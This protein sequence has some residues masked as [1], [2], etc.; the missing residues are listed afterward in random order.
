MAAPVLPHIRI[1]A[2]L[3]PRDGRF[4]SGPSKVPAGA[5]ARLG[6]PESASLLGTSH[7]QDPVR[8]LVASVRAGMRALWSLPDDVA[9]VLGNGGASQFWDVAAASLIGEHSQ[10]TVFGEFGGKFA[11]AVAGA[12][13]L[14]DPDVIE[15]HPGTRSEPAARAGID[16]YALVHN[17]TSTGVVG[18]A[19]RPA[20]TDGDA[21]VAVDATS[22]AGA[23]PTDHR[24]WDLYYF[25]PQKVF[26]S[27]GGLWC[28]LLNP[29]ARARVAD[30]RAGESPRWRPASLDLGAAIEQSE[31]D[32]TTNTPAIATLVLL[33]E[34]LRWLNDN[35]GIDFAAG[36]SGASAAILYDWAERT[37]WTAPFVTDPALR[38]PVVGTIDFDPTV[39][40]PL[41]A[42]TLRANG[43]VDTE[44]Y[45]KLGRNQLRIGMFPAVDA[46]DVEALTA[47]IDHVVG[48]L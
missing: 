32:Q 28:A 21:I 34:Q 4:G 8:R 27:D 43:V 7:R 37:A 22:G 41:V 26:A 36:R 30:L 9:V 48:R 1:P 11:A 2:D 13:H 19:V 42:A 31:L 46:A 6:A 20:S 25:A 45:R 17:E 3:L 29:A 40:A 44:P 5:I 16:F 38:S 10:H 39:P 23:L 35:G 24:D 47:C 33:D 15:A 14:A 18:S 12:P